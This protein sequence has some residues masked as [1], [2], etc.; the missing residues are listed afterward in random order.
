LVV[1]YPGEEHTD[2]VVALLQAAGRQVAR[3]DLADYPGR[4]GLDLRWDR[5]VL[6]LMLGTG[7]GPVDLDGVK[8]VWWRRVR[9][10][11]CDPAVTDPHAR[12][13]IASETH[14]A[15]GGVL[16]SLACPWMNPPGEDEA[17]HRKPFQW[18]VAREAGLRLPDTLVTTDPA[19]ARAFLG[20]RGGG[21]TVFKA[22]LATEQGWRE[23]RLVRDEDLA[24]LDTVRLAPVIFQEYVDGVDLRVTI[25][26]G[27]VFAAEIDATGTSYP[28]D[29]RMVIGEAQIRP[30]ELPD[31][32]EAALHRLM[33]RLGLVYGAIDLRRRPDGTHMFF[34]VNP[35]GQW[36]FVEQRT[37]LPITAAVATTLQA[38]ADGSA[39]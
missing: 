28:A 26:G 37:G 19:S 5:E 21:R 34:E 39:A 25:V 14:Q 20:E 2:A 1:S 6:R 31:E 33:S 38:M 29:M 9:P 15:I 8:A 32:V 12:Q 7:D 11:G 24:K 13:F 10:F 18:A 36:M 23:T 16:S 27:R 3:I 22:F 30:V 17:A 4:Y 35:A